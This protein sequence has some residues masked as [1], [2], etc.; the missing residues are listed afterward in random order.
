MAQ[1][2]QVATTTMFPFAQYED[3][4]AA[5]EWLCN[6][7]GFERHEVHESEERPVIH[8][9]LAYGSS[10]FMLGSAGKNELGLETPGKLGAVT[11]GVYVVVEDIDAHY[12]RARAA[13]AEIVR[14][15]ADTSYGSREYLAR[16]LEGN[17]WSFGTYRPNV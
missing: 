9:E 10:V 8:A 7:F 17:L 14:E 4:H 15:L 13:G 5:I 1:Q 6:A 16:D 12:E 2:V 3:A 11:G